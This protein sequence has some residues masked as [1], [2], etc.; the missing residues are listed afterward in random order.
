MLRSVNRKAGSLDWLWFWR[1]AVCKQVE[2]DEVADERE[3]EDVVTVAEEL[4]LDPNVVENRRVLCGMCVGSG[5]I[6]ELIAGSGPTDIMIR[7]GRMGF[8]VLTPPARSPLTRPRSLSGSRATLLW[9]SVKSSPARVI[10][11]SFLM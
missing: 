4:V 7:N 2:D 11:L 9:G 10:L 8:P 1:C 6:A 3:D 5:A